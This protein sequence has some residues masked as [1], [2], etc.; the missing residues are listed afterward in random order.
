[1]IKVILPCKN[2]IH[3]PACIAAIRSYMK[4]QAAGIAQAEQR[5]MESVD[6][7]YD[8]CDKSPYCR[9]YRCD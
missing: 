3:N 6:L 2:C 1:M 9:H 8:S 5:S 7:Q 4:L